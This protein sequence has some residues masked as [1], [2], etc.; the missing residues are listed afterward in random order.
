MHGVASTAVQSASNVGTGQGAFKQKT[1]TDLEFKSFTGGTD[2]SVTPVGDD[3]EI[4]YT[5]G[6]L[7]SSNQIIEDNS[8]V[9]VVDNGIAKGT[10]TF[11][12]DGTDVWQIDGS[13]HFVPQTGATYNIGAPSGNGALSIYTSNLYALTEVNTPK[14]DSNTGVSLTLA[15]GGTNYWQIDQASGHLIPQGGSS[16]QDIGSG[17]N[18]V[19]SIYVDAV[20]S[21]HF[22]H[23]DGATTYDW[24]LNVDVTDPNNPSLKFNN[25]AVGGSG[26]SGNY[27]DLT[28]RPSDLSDFN[29]DLTLNN[30]PNDL[31]S[32]DWSIV[33][34]TPT[35][36]AGYAITDPIV[37]SDSSIA[38]QPVR[39]YY[40]NQAAF[41]SATDWHGAI[42]HSHSDG[43]MYF[44]HGASWNKLANASDI[45]TDLTDLGISD[46]S[47]NQVLTTDGNGAFSFSSVSSGGFTSFKIY[48][49]GSSNTP[50]TINLSLIHI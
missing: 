35:D 21:V 27:N 28:N 38:S 45:P 16:T 6:G 31:T 36:L 2:I 32:V 17:A 18:R 48:E 37:L 49:N 10:I 41:P 7:I 8:S 40:A 29:N 30:F 25:Q 11:N 24:A 23:V 33:A 39:Q 5:G 9:T 13:G 46:G 44:A 12:I 3:L 47:A 42:A 19:Q 43:A 22:I 4:S 20:S 14:V 15:A 34:N 26:F 50:T 1:G